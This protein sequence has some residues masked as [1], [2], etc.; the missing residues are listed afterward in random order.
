MIIPCINS[1]SFGERSGS[2]ALVDGGNIRV[3]CPGA[4]GCTI[5][6]SL[7]SVCCAQTGSDKK[8]ARTAAAIIVDRSLSP[9]LK[10]NEFISVDVASIN[11]N[12]LPQKKSPAHFCPVNTETDRRNKRSILKLEILGV[13][14]GGNEKEAL[15]ENASKNLVPTTRFELVTYRV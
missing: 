11:W 1:T 14:V 10:G 5:T 2:F 8:H 9:A 6:G 12:I 3:G 7:G 15:F 4:P 13:N